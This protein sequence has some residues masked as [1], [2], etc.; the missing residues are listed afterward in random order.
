MENRKNK[1]VFKEKILVPFRFFI[2]PFVEE[3]IIIARYG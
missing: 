1:K 2:V 3:S